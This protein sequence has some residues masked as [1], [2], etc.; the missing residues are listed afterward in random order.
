MNSPKIRVIGV[1]YQNK[2]GEKYYSKYFTKHNPNISKE[3]FNL[4]NFEGQ[5]KF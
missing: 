3:Q 1:V 4:D 5:K 2:F